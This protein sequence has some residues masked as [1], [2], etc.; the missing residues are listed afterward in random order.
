MHNN[1]RKTNGIQ[2]EFFTQA[3]CWE[4]YSNTKN[5]VVA[6]FMKDPDFEFKN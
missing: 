5:E 4:Y 2:S 1:F 6:H 3:L